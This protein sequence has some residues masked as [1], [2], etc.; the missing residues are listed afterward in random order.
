MTDHRRHLAE[1]REILDK[2]YLN[3]WQERTLSTQHLFVFL[4][5]IVSRVELWSSLVYELLL[6]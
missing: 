6:T 2:T 4:L 5:A 1:V 3:L